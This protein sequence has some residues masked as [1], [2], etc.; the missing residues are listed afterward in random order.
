MPGVQFVAK[1][2]GWDGAE[3][4]LCNIIPGFI[5]KELTRVTM[6]LRR[7]LLIYVSLVSWPLFPFLSVFHKT[8]RGLKVMFSH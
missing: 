1:M 6:P 5:P 3:T 7:H 4:D 8:F 2:R